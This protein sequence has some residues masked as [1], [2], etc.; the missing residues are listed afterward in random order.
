MNDTTTNS[1]DP[2]PDTPPDR[3]PEEL[4][5]VINDAINCT[6]NPPYFD[7]LPKWSEARNELVNR[8]MTGV[9]PLLERVRKERDEARE[10]A[11]R[12]YWALR[13][14]DNIVRHIRTTIFPGWT[15]ASDHD[16]NECLRAYEKEHGITANY[17]ARSA[18]ETRTT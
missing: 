3:S 16:V 5:A 15:N 13:E 9:F 4:L 8:L 7:K 12:Q 17:A 2:T 6:N 1:P 18:P 10:V 11:R 14:G